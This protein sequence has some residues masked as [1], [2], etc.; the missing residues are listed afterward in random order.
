MN[1]NVTFTTEINGESQDAT[2]YVDGVVKIAI[3]LLATAD[4]NTISGLL[5]QVGEEEK[6]FI[7]AAMSGIQRHFHGK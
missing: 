4:E 7:N 2:N 3:L 5:S 6:I 1:D